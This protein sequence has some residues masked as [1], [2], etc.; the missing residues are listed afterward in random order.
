M[1]RLQHFQYSDTDFES[2]SRINRNKKNGLFIYLFMKV[3]I[4]L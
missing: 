2:Y 4:N 3:K 1:Q